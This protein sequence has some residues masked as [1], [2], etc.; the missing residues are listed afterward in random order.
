MAV[1]KHSDCSDYF[2]LTSKLSGF[3]ESA[4]INSAEVQNHQSKTY[5]I[6]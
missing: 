2:L 3:S 6:F 5:L 4:K 1:S